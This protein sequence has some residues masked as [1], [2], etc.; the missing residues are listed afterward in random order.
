MLN[1]CAREINVIRIK[2]KMFVNKLYFRNKKV[3]TEKCA[4]LC[5]QMTQG[6]YRELF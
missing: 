2:V 4:I 5:V 6:L 1:E 3:T